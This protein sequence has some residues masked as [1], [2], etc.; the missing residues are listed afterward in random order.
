MSYPQPPSPEPRY[1]HTGIAPGFAPGMPGTAP[2]MAPP[3]PPAPTSAAA[4][5]SLVLAILGSMC[6]GPIGAIA[7]I[8]LGAVAL[9][10]IHSSQGKKSGSVL[11]W[12]GVVIGSLTTL[13][14][15]AVILLLVYTGSSAASP[16]PSPIYMPPPLPTAT[17]V[18]SPTPGGGITETREVRTTD[19][20]VGAVP[21]VDIGLSEPSLE[22]ALRKQ[23]TLAERDGHKLVLQ[24]TSTTC[25]PCQGVAAALTDPKMQAALAGVRLVRVDVHDFHEELTEMGIPHE[26]IPGFFFLGTDLSPRDG[27]HGGEWDDDTAD[28]IAPVVGPF[29]RGTYVRRRHP[30]AAPR[31]PAPR[32]TAL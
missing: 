1:P 18:P 12:V 32:G 20:R 31:G 5:A 17:A 6:L 22:A 30:F 19:T 16:A 14:Y 26:S 11:A 24:T 7:A 9:W 25:R 23:R 27:I 13:A 15:A 3:P 29:V 8:I 21:V 10:D 4:T 28:N 2:G